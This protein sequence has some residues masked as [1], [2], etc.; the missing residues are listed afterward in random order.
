MEQFTILDVVRYNAYLNQ[1]EKPSSNQ[2]I[3]DFTQKLVNKITDDA[4][5]KRLINFSDWM[6]ISYRYNNDKFNK[7]LLSIPFKIVEGSWKIEECDWF[8]DIYTDMI[9]PKK[10]TLCC[11]SCKIKLLSNPKEL[12]YIFTEILR[13]KFGYDTHLMC[14]IDD[15][16]KLYICNL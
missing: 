10:T 3:R 2:T 11:F 12:F 16:L 8:M 15:I 13:Q 7:N 14:I 4:F 5:K 6:Y 1:L 9:V